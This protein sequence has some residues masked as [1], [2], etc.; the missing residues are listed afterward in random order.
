MSQNRSNEV[1]S[2]EIKHLRDDVKELKTEFRTELQELELR[3][4]NAEDNA[5]R[6]RETLTFF[7]E[8]MKEVKVFFTNLNDKIDAQNEK[9]DAQ[10]KKIDDFISGDTRVQNKRAFIV[11]V[12]QVASGIVVAGIGLVTALAQEWIKL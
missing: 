3:V 10:N 7:G 1:L 11:S 5:I 2:M 8:A 6:S 12:L 9:I 4:R